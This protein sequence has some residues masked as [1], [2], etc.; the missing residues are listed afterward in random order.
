MSDVYNTLA[1]QAKLKQHIYFRLEK[2]WS[3]L[4]F[5]TKKCQQK[6]VSKA[7]SWDLSR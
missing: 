2:D 3:I 6:M 4:L 1:A 7:S 5:V